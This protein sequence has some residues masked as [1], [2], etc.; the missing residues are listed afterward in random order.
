MPDD[1]P[2]WRQ[3]G[4]LGLVDDEPPFILRPLRIRD[5]KSIPHRQWIYGTHIIRG[6][7]SLLVA[8]GGTGKSSLILG[9]G[10]AC[11]TQR[12]LLGTVVHQQVNVAVLNLE[13]PQEEV[14]RRVTALSMRYGISDADISDRVFMTPEG[15]SVVIAAKGDDGFSV[16]HP[17]ERAIIEKVKDERIGLLAV[18]PYAESHAL[19]ENSN[20]DMVRA[21]A[22]WR[23]VARIGNCAVLLAHHVRKG[24]VD[25]IEAARGAKAL[26]DSA[27]VGL[28]LS[29]MSEAEADTLGVAQDDRLKYARLDDAK[30]NLA[31][32]APKAV[33]FHLATVTLDNATE[34]YPKGDGVVVIEQWQPQSVFAGFSDAQ[35][36][37]ALDAIEAGTDDGRRFSARREDAGRWAGQVFID[38]FGLTEGSASEIIRTWVKSGLLT[39]R[40]YH[41]SVTRKE[42]NGLFVNATKRP[43]ER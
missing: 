26:T 36:N 15:R 28:L 42:R 9:I 31:P 32:R 16:I 18:D 29:T 8:P 11:A 39:L 33:W 4:F 34:L 25:S 6:Y 21:A 1:T 43:G 20:P 35:L 14:D 13:D 30:A 7:V 23:R 2:R 3:Q 22:A 17:D 19:E 27:R 10:M 40:K 12:N 37:E 38:L 41:D 24:T 5:Q